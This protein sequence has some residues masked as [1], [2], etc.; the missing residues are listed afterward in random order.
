LQSSFYQISPT[1]PSNSTRGSHLVP[2][3]SYPSNARITAPL[4]SGQST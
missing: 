2:S 3:S 1:V 4:R